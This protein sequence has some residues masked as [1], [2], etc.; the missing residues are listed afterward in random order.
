MQDHS[1]HKLHVIMALAK[2]TLGGFANGGKGLVH[3]VVEAVLEV[4]GLAP[5]GVIAQSR[6]FRLQGIDCQGACPEGLDLAII[7][8]AEEFFSEAEHELV[9]W[10]RGKR[11]GEA[12]TFEDRCGQV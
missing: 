9:R 7:G 6:V 11:P 3:D 8:G 1:A 4:L 10:S 5:Q 12:G 2:C